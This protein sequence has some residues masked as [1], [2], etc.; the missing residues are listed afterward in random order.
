VKTIFT[1]IR[2]KVGLEL[3]ILAITFLLLFPHRN[4][5]LDIILAGFALLC[6]LATARYTKN[7]IW[8]ALPP[9]KSQHPFKDCLKV[10]LWITLPTVLIFFLIGGIL[11]YR[12]GGWPGVTER[13]FDWKILVI[14]IA[15][16]A[17]AFIQQTLFQFYLLGRLLV[18]LPKNQP[19]WPI[20]ITGL[21]FSLVHLPDI[22][23]VLATCVAG[24]IW[25]LIYYRYRRLLPLAVSHA[26]LGT[27]FYYGICGHNLSREWQSALTLLS[28]HLRNFYLQIRVASIGAVLA[29]PLLT[30]GCFIP[31]V[32]MHTTRNAAIS[33][34]N[35]LSRQPVS[36]LPFRVHYYYDF[37]TPLYIHYEFRTPHELHAKTDKAG[38]AIIPLAD[39]GGRIVLNGEIASQYICF[40][41]DKHFVRKGGFMND[42]HEPPRNRL[43]LR[44]IR[45]PTK[46]AH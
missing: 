28:I 29:L 4:P 19:V 37:L 26:A 34:T 5:W 31:T 40:E 14:F 33:I 38:E 2:Q 43:T 25:T 3:G 18:L 12:N 9:P 13:I 41:F 30:S 23:T 15:Y 10:T 7:V 45:K 16:T 27:A 32:S 36:D 20:L 42:G 1:T 22:W 8:A 11:A 17:W 21:G 46:L 24:P 39:Y 35:V 44:T 6:I